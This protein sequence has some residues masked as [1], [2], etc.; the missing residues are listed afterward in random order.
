[1]TK[2]DKKNTA[3]SPLSGMLEAMQAASTNMMPVMGPEWIANMN[4]LGTEM[5]EF[6]AHRVKQD[7]QTQQDL[8][9]AKDI[10]EVQKIQAEF[11]KKTMDDYSA[12]MTKLM[13]LG[14]KHS[15]HATPV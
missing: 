14:E 10:A 8:L 13:G 4:T 6:M 9:Q 1:M 3:A 11:L 5:M 15:R 2:D 7:L 12:E